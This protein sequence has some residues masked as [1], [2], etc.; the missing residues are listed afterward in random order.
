MRIIRD[1]EELKEA[2]PSAITLGTFDG[3]HLGHRRI[4]DIL[5]MT[6]AERRLQSVLIT[7]EPHPQIVLRPDRVPELKLLTTTEEKLSLLDAAGVEVCFVMKFSSEMASMTGDEFVR[8]ILFEGLNMRVCILG[9]DHAFGKN[10]SAHY[11]TVKNLGLQWGFDVVKIEPVQPSGQ[12]ISSTM[13]RNLIR[14]GHVARA[15]DFLGRPY[16]LKGAVTEGSKRGRQIGFPTAN[17]EVPDH[18]LI[19]RN[20]VYACLAKLEG[21]TVKAMVN[22]GVRPTFNSAERPTVEAHLL[23]WTGNLYGSMLE[24]LFLDRIRDEQRFESIDAL[25]AAIQEDVKIAVSKIFTNI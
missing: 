18:K 9:H 3:V 11:D 6:A 2:R 13:I 17:I 20:G 25:R 21:Q 15:K 4:L 14:E 23:E 7:F 5:R 19:P 12:V 16:G 1:L 8:K 22:I 24:L 10:R